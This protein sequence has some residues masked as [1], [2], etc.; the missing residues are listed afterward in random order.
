MRTPGGPKGASQ[1]GNEVKTENPETRGPQDGYSCGSGR[2]GGFVRHEPDIPR[3]S[4]SSCPSPT[5]YT[6]GP[7]HDVSDPDHV[8]DRLWPNPT[9]DFCRV[10]DSTRDNN[11]Q[12]GMANI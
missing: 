10:S 8:Q 4:T 5:R 6:S 12:T 3:V 1:K 9:R 2:I 11:G 7:T